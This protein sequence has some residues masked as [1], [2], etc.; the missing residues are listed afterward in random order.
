M[1]A[2][3]E[4]AVATAVVRE[5]AGLAAADSAAAGLAAAE[6]VEATEARREVWAG[7]REEAARGRNHC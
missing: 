7:N 2:V 1:R 4:R 5:V 6:R 3:G